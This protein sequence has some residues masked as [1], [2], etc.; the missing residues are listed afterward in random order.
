MRTKLSGF[1]MLSTII[2]VCASCASSDGPPMLAPIGGAVSRIDVDA[3][4]ISDVTTDSQDVR[5]MC[6]QMAR[7]LINLQQISNAVS[8]PRIAFLEMVNRTTED[9]DS[10]NLLDSIRTQLV[11]N[12]GGRVIFV[13]RERIN[14][15]MNERQM[16]R[17][18]TVGASGPA[19]LSG[20]DFFLTGRAYS[21]MRAYR[22]VRQAYYRFS[23]RLT[24]AERGDIIWE[25]EYEF[26]KVG[27]LGFMNR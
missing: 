8:P 21:D 26:K 22:G 20:V 6:Q 9:I 1:F 12:S 24:D 18:G 13:D 16:K 15:I 2:I 23:F 25:D 19:V 3:S 17:A 4:L 5:S 11:K 14:S 27:Q 10:Y 7:S